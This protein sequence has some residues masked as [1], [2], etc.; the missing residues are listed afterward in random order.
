M[1]YLGDAILVFF[2]PLEGPIQPAIRRSTLC[3]LDMEKKMEGINTD[4]RTEG[5]PELKMGIGVNSGEVVVGNIGS[6]TLAKYGI[7]GS[8]VN[9][10]QRIQSQAEE[11]EVI[12]SDSVYRALPEHLIISS[13]FKTTLKGIQ[14]PVTLHR[15]KGFQGEESKI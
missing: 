1:I 11:G 6:E 5:L 12:V 13:S 9:I 7:V 15:V 10:T 8:A 4:N 14:E 2:D 3:A